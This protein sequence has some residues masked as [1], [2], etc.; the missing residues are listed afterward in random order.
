VL[1]RCVRALDVVRVWVGEIVAI[2]VRVW[3]LEL[4][5]LRMCIAELIIT[6]F[7]VLMPELELVAVRVRRY[8]VL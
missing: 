2:F 7:W 4:H 6:L 3:M 8:L 1:L 5:R